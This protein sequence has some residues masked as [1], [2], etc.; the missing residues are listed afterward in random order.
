MPVVT[1]LTEDSV[2][3]LKLLSGGF[4]KS[5]Y[6]NKYKVIDNSVVAIAAANTK[7]T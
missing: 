7:N 2:K 5:V 4:K 6:W 1:L 3:L